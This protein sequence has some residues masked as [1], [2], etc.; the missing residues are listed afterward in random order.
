MNTPGQHS[1][2]QNWVRWLPGAIAVLVLV[3]LLVWAATDDKKRGERRHT[4]VISTT[5]DNSPL[6]TFA[7]SSQCGICHAASPGARALRDATGA[8]V[9]PFD[10][11]RSSMM[12]NAARDPFW[13][14]VVSAE[15]AATP[16]RK[17]DIE[18]KCIRCHAPMAAELKMDALTENTPAAHLARDGVSCTVCHQILPDG[19]GEATSFTGGFKIGP[20]KLIFGPH[21][22]PR[23]RPMIKNSGFTP[24]L[25]THILRSALCATCHTL[26]TDALAPDGREVGIRFPE[27]AIYLEWQNSIFNNEGDSGRAR[28][29]SCQSCHEPRTS[30]DGREISTPIAHNPQGRDYRGIPDRAVGRHV[31]VGGNT[32]IP[33]ILR[34]NAQQLA[35]LA[36]SEAFDETIRRAQRQLENATAR[37]TIESLTLSGDCIEFAVMVENLAGHKFPTGFPSRRAWLH[38]IVRDE[39]GRLVFSSGS[40][41]REGRIVGPDQRPLRSES[42]AGPIEPHR[43]T[44]TDSTHVQIYEAIMG[45][46]GGAPTWTLLRASHYLKDNRLLPRGWSADHP[47]AEITHPAGVANDADF[48]AAQ[49]KVLYQVKVSGAGPYRVEAELLYE[50]IGVR[51]VEELFAHTTPEIAAFRELYLAASRTPVRIAVAYAEVR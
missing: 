2:G 41:D 47:Q 25:G 33:A 17:S 22:D 40:F 15:V 9:A 28:A 45:Q 5:A 20:E 31:F 24:V 1:K 8:T 21:P 34:D 49:D 19:M 11:W 12:A 13:R 14:A 39:N 44:I 42:P 35:V 23:A 10:L 4:K 43:S 37:L 38:V 32:L 6:P 26:I 16:S 48:S 7:D 50:V 29:R 51:F 27:Q 36:P 18:A 30:E 46:Q 3:P